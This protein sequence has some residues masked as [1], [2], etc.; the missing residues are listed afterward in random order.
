MAF[1]AMICETNLKKIV[2]KAQFGYGNGGNW[3]SNVWKS[4]QEREAKGYAVEM[5]ALSIPRKLI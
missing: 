2:I 3:L 1:L 4:N 5:N